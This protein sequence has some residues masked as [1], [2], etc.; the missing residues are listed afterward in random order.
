MSEGRSTSE[1]ELRR[2]LP[3]VFERFNG[4]IATGCFS[5]N[6]ARIQTLV[7]IAED[8]GR[9]PVVLGRSLHKMIEAARSTGYLDPFESE[10]E[11]RDFGYLPPGNTFL[12]CTGTQAEPG[13]ALSRISTNDHPDV[14]LGRGDA[15]VFSSKIIPGNE[16]PIDTLHGRLR[17]KGARV[18]TERD[19]FVHVSGHPKRD[20]LRLLY[21]WAR[22]RIAVPV[23]GEQPHMRAHAELARE[24]GVPETIVPFDGAVIR[25]AP[26]PAKIVG[27]VPA[28]RV[29]V[30]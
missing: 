28:G 8:L 2:N 17:K 12:I 7:K 10:V 13:A 4:R 16:D 29:I 24:C 11:S 15:V 19:A 1:G 9:H 3:R 21:D 30:R 5:S 25:L 20:D 27:Q 22:P 18:V 14:H 6:I 23:H 26:G